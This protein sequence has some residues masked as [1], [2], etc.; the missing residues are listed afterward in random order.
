[1]AADSAAERVAGVARN[2]PTTS[3]RRARRETGGIGI[4]NSSGDFFTQR[5]MADSG[6][7]VKSPSHLEDAERNSGQK[8]AVKACLHN[9]R[10]D[11]YS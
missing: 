1:V 8:P 7:F 9:R 3:K 4:G 2:A 10:F 5:T 6:C 11:G